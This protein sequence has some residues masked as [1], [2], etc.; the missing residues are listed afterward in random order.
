MNVNINDR[1]AKKLGVTRQAVHMFTSGKRKWPK[2][3]IE[4]ALEELRL[5]KEE[6]MLLDL[7]LNQE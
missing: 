6:A 4:I 7:N 2:K 3:H 1:I 5:W